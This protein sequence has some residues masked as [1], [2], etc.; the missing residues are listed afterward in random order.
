M[1]DNLV[2]I[3]KAACHSVSPTELFRRR[4]EPKGEAHFFESKSEAHLFWGKAAVAT[5]EALGD[6]GGPELVVRGEHP[7]PGEGSFR[8]GAAILDFFDSIG[9]FGC[10]R[11][12]VYLSGGSSSLAWVKPASL[13]ESELHSQLL[14]LYSKPLPIERLNQERAKLCA[15]KGGGAARWVGRLAPKA[16]VH[17]WVISDV[18]PYGPEVVGSGPFWDGKIPHTV[19]ADNTSF[20]RA[21][22]ARARAAGLPVLFSASGQL[23]DWREW[24]GRLER[25]VNRAFRELRAGSTGLILLGGEPQVALPRNLRV[26]Q[27]GGGRQSHIAAALALRFGDEIL[28]RRLELLCASSDGSDGNSNSAGTWID[29]RAL[30]RLGGKKGRAALAG[31]LHDYSTAALFRKARALI[32]ARQ[33]G[34]NV[35]DL[36]LIRVK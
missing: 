20:T 4:S 12:E 36:I 21:A 32:P 14:K 11:L 6:L 34:T 3:W 8:S 24:V 15:L 22:M 2:S 26:L 9:R 10:K 31:A 16:R 19:L 23:G 5:R 29:H 7:L 25:E 35:Q 1:S 18:Q 33:T 30:A 17:V 13:S 28:S 27:F